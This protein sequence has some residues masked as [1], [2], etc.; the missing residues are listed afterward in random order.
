[1]RIDSQLFSYVAVCEPFCYQLYNGLL[2]RAQPSI[3]VSNGLDFLGRSVFVDILRHAHPNPHCGGN[4]HKHEDESH[5]KLSKRGKCSTWTVGSL[6][7]ERRVFVVKTQ[8]PHFFVHDTQHLKE[9]WAR[10]VRNARRVQP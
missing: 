4:Q 10:I 6:P 9:S 3:F 7:F 5:N 8:I 2:S 1:M